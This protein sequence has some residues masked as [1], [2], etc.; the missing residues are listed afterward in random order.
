M[1]EYHAGGL[2]L[3]NCDNMQLMRS[4]DDDYFDLAIVDTPY[5][6]GMSKN[7][8]LS[9]KYEEKNWDD[10]IPA[11]QYF[12][13]LIRVSKNQIIWGGNYFTEFLE[14]VKG[15]LLSMFGEDPPIHHY[16]PH[17]DNNEPF[18]SLKDLRF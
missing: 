17:I 1:T 15:W 4:Y 9:N 6:I 11:E 12:S 7:A 8:G 18:D 10:S 13:E 2:H 14:P 16:A 5:G 3:Y